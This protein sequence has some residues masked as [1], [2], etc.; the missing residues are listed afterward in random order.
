MCRQGR[1]C[2]PRKIVEVCPL[3]TSRI[4]SVSRQN[5]RGV[6]P[7]CRQ[8]WRRQPGKIV[9]DSECQP[10]KNRRGVPLCVARQD[11]EHHPAKIA[12]VCSM[13]AGR[14]TSFSRGKAVEVRLL[15]VGR[16][17]SVSRRKIVEVCSM[18]A[19]RTAGFSRGKVVEVRLLYVDRT[20]RASAVEKSSRCVS[21]VSA[22]QRAP[23]SKNRR[24]LPPGVGKI[25][26]LMETTNLVCRNV[27]YV[28]VG[29]ERWS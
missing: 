5:R 8:D 15:Y 17:P 4:A 27:A 23:V 20:A 18:C 29:V 22:G 19:G 9:E 7:V 25:R 13:C 11:S 3:C 2:Q 14:T 24:G 6:P 10:G 16:T 26:S 1:K 21:W 12:E 28:S